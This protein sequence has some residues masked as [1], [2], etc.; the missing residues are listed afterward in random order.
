[1]GDKYLKDFSNI[2]KEC[3]MGKGFFARIGGDEFVA[4]L[5]GKNLNMADEIISNMNEKL[6]ELNKKDPL[7][8]RSMAYGYAYKSEVTSGYENGVY[9]LADQRMYENKNLLKNQ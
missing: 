3:F 4:I 5:T 6:S 2:L 9:L 8:N 7:I 1:M